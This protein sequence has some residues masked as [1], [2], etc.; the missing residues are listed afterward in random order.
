LF[1]LLGDSNLE[2]LIAF[3][4]NFIYS[5]YTAGGIYFIFVLYGN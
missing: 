4:R 5:V 3:G 2:P 1:F